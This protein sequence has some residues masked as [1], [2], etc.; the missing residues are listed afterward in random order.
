MT[1]AATLALLVGLAAP[2]QAA[3]SSYTLR[4]P[5]GRVELRVATAERLSFGVRLGSEL[6]VDGATLSL[7][8]DHVV[9]GVRPKVRSAKTTRVDRVV[10][11]PVPRRSAKIPERYAELRLEMEGRY[12]VVFRAYD[13]GAAYRFETSPPQD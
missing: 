12:P 3:E 1:R 5:D 6:L 7:D 11:A 10:E 9:L 4:S 13:D 2:G 8:V